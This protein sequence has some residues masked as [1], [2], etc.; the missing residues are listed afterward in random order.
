MAAA[1]RQLLEERYCSRGLL[2]IEP[3]AGGARP[4]ERFT[5]GVWGRWE[6][7]AEWIADHLR[8]R[9]SEAAGGDGAEV[10]ARR[11]EGGGEAADENDATATTSAAGEAAAGGRSRPA[12]GGEG[13]AAPGRRARGSE[14]VESDRGP[15]AARSSVAPHPA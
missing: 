10:A 1:L 6:E 15:F 7:G 14:A 13:G 3:G 12:L 8:G 4:L 2:A 11:Q 9:R 5:E